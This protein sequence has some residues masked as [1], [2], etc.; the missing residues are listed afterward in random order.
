MKK[1]TII[2]HIGTYKTGTSAIQKFLQDNEDELMELGVCYP[3]FQV[4]EP[5]HISY[6]KNGDFL[7]S[8]DEYRSKGIPFPYVDLLV[9]VAKEYGKLLIS[10]ETLWSV[11]DKKGFFSAYCN[12]GVDI[13]VIVYLRRQDLYLESLVNQAIQVNKNYVP[14]L[15]YHFPECA[16]KL[17]VY[18]GIDY[19]AELE[20]IRT[21]IGREN[22][23]V[24]LYDK[25]EYLGGKKDIYSEF[26]SFLSVEEDKQM[27]L[28]RPT[29]DVNP[30]F[31]RELMEMKRCFNRIP[32][33]LQKPINFQENLQK[34]SG[35]FKEESKFSKH[36]FSEEHAKEMLLMFEESNEKLRK[37]YFPDR[38]APL[39]STNM[40]GME[41]PILEGPTN[42]IATVTFGHLLCESIGNTEAQYQQLK[43]KYQA[44]QEEFASFRKEV[45]D[46]MVENNRQ[47]EEYKKIIG[48]LQK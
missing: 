17:P 27:P 44:L 1:P 36:L 37:T 14:E 19:F 41:K 3:T 26:L 11:R 42:E 30:S 31:H 39:F 6:E 48:E 8:F 23:I 16:N 40:T 45:E 9:D 10:S 2:F 4:D 33:F 25:A 24:Q 46:Y 22:M 32:V 21:V 38:P 47:L 20:Q 12:Q 5:D 35:F 13:K 7:V 29:G 34:I 28:M 43:R 18:P 15:P